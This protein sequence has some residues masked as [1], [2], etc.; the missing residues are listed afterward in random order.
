MA[1]AHDLIAYGANVGLKN[2]QGKTALQ[3]AYANHMVRLARFLVESSRTRQRHKKYMV[4]SS[5][6]RH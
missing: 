3:I 1:L 6:T 2:K 5:A 4:Q